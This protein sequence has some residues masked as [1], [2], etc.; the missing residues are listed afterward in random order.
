MTCE[1]AVTADRVPGVWG[2]L[3]VGNSGS[4]LYTKYGAQIDAADVVVRLNQAP[5]QGNS[6]P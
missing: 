1:C 3:Q 6:P 5:T 2:D 4:L